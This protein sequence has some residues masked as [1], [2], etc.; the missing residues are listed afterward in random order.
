[1]KRQKIIEYCESLKSVYKNY[2]FGDDSWL[3]YRIRQNNKCFIFIYEYQGK[4]RINLKCDPDKAD[5][6][7]QIHSSVV[8]AY[9]M[10]KQ[11]WNSVILDGNISRND[12][13]D[14]I[15]HSFELCHDKKS[16]SP[17]RSYGVSYRSLYLL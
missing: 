8:P 16:K 6:L 9:H 10:N 13:L 1:M 7:R 17:N 11:H 14:M 12:I 4:D 5:F 15:D 3:A 2:P